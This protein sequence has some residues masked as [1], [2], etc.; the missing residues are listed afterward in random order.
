MSALF[1]NLCCDL[2]RISNLKKVLISGGLA[3][4]EVYMQTHADVLN[5]EVITFSVGEADL[6]LIGAAIL[7]YHSALKQ[8]LTQKV[9]NYPQ[10]Q[11]KRFQPSEE[12]QK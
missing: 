4:N 12:L 6:M 7:A 2:F 1:T 11:A 10:L 8:D 3:K 9:I 5:I